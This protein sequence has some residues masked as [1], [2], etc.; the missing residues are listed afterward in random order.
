MRKAALL[1]ASAL[2]ALLLSSGAAF[3][4]IIIG[5]QGAD[6]LVGTNSNDY[7]RGDGGNDSLQGKA[8]TIPTSRS[9][10]HPRRIGDVGL[11]W[12]AGG[13][14]PGDP[15][16]LESNFPN[17]VRPYITPP[18][19]TALAS[20]LALVPARTR[21]CPSATRSD[22]YDAELIR[23]RTAIVIAHRLST[24]RHA[25]VIAVL[26]GASWSWATTTS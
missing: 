2:A 13:S 3:A 1:F 16:S 17:P 14:S 18:H 24:V 9:G 21:R 5:T 4:E 25:D 26:E 8:V 7:I 6:N 22:C 20:T 15:G 12:R 19:K 11:R 10:G 23:G